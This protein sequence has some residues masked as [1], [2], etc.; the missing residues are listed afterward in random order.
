MRRLDPRVAL[1]TGGTTGTGVAAAKALV[2]DAATV[3]AKVKRLFES[4]S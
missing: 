2:Q 3:D 1:A 4:A